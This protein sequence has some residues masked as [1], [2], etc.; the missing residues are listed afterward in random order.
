MS[1]IALIFRTPR[2]TRFKIKERVPGHDDKIHLEIVVTEVEEQMVS[3]QVFY[4]S[5]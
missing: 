1:R 5:L 3:N 2:P 4:E